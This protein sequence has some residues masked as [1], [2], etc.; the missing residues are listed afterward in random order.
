MRP[1]AESPTRLEISFPSIRPPSNSPL[2]PLSQPFPLIIRRATNV[3]ERANRFKQDRPCAPCQSRCSNG[4]GTPKR[5]RRIEGY[6]NL[7]I[8]VIGDKR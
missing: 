7:A 3:S 5:F 4:G 8:R 6:D 2:N 1:R